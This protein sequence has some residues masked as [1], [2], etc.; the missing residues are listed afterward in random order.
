MSLAA[1][2]PGSEDRGDL[3]SCEILRGPQSAPTTVFE[4]ATPSNQV[5]AF[6]LFACGAARRLTASEET[7]RE[8]VRALS[9]SDPITRR[10][11]GTCLAE[12]GWR[13]LFLLNAAVASGALGLEKAIPCVAEV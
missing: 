9:S 6:Y 13:S 3:D 10:V 4:L 2:S 7:G 1:E 8:L 11:A 5:D 12:V